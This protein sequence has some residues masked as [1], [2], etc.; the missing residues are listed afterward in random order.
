MCFSLQQRWH[1]CHI[2]VCHYLYKLLERGFLRIPMQ[3]GTRFGGVAP[4]VHDIGRPVEIG[5]YFHKDAP[6]GFVYAFFVG[7]AALPFYVDANIAESERGE[8]TH[9]VLLS[10]GD[11]KILG[12]LMLEYEPHAFHIVFG[13]S[14]VTHARKIAEIQF[15]LLALGYTCCGKG[16]FAGDERL[17]TSL[18]QLVKIMTDADMAKVAV[19][20]AGESVRTNLAEYLEKGIVK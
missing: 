14:P 11:Y 8:F 19:E 2:G 17:A 4:Q 12:S 7:T 20:R 10:C 3:L 5:R 6:R 9:G 18:E 15:V 1:F 16:D 13:I